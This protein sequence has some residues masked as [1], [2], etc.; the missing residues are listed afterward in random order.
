EDVAKIDPRFVTYNDKGEVEGI[1][2]DRMS[3]AFVNAFREQQDEI[4]TLRKELSEQQETVKKQSEMIS[5][6]R[7]EFRK[8]QE[9]LD[10]LKNLVCSQSPSASICRSMQEE[11]K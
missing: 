6:Q 1:K 4:A 9:M 8:Q 5:A 3:A 10:A 11:K 7:E 2:Y